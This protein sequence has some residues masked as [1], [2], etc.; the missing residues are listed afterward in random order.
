MSLLL[1]VPRCFTTSD[2]QE[3][4]LGGVESSHR[5]AANNIQSRSTAILYSIKVNQARQMEG[6]R[7]ESS[8]QPQSAS[9]PGS[10][11][12]KIIPFTRGREEA[13][14]KELARE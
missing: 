5:P 9:Q 3:D 12:K 8:D 10:T 1:A 13:R 7:G 6:E 14:H 2:E 4:W 11:N